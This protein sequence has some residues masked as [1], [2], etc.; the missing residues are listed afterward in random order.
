MNLN[1]ENKLAL[2]TASSGG[3]GFEIAR[4]LVREGARVIINGRS[5]ASVEKAILKLHED[6]P[7]CDLPKT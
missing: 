2:V 4:S 5:S 3:I 6:F 1:L 7:Q